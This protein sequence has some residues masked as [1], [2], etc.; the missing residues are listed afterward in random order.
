MTDRTSVLKDTVRVPAPWGA[1]G[2][3][4]YMTGTQGTS[5]LESDNNWVFAALNVSAYAEF[6]EL[7][8]LAK[9]ANIYMDEALPM[10]RY[11]LEENDPL[12]MQKCI[13]AHL[14]RTA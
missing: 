9:Q 12:G 1:N 3:G 11:V 2:P 14:Q 4:F 8:D 10:F 5:S 7:P 13:L 6:L